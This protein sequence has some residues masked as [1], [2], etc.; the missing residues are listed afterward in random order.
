[1]IIQ[2]ERKRR[3]E[4]KVNIKIKAI[5][6]DPIQIKTR[7]IHIKFP[8]LGLEDM[9]D[10]LSHAAYL[11]IAKHVDMTGTGDETYIL[12]RDAIRST[13]EKYV[14]AFDKCGASSL[15]WKLKE[16]DPWSKNS[17][18]SLPSIEKAP[19]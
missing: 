15:C 17:Y 14:I 6:T 16:F 19:R 4:N 11:A 3:G 8:K 18:P 7:Q 13:F 10:D 1:M 12:V 5:E 2:D 9:V